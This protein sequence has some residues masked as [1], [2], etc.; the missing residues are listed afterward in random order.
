MTLNHENE[1]NRNNADVE[2]ADFKEHE[3][4]LQPRTPRTLSVPVLR[5]MPGGI[6]GAGRRGSGRTHQCRP[7]WPEQRDEVIQFFLR[8]RE[9]T[10][11]ACV[12]TCK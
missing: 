11:S 6:D 5:R 1:A 2:H 10:S 7:L 8:E 9:G 3:I 12:L 4:A